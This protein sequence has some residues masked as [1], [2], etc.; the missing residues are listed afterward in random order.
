MRK[1]ATIG[2]R[3]FKMMM[4]EKSFIMVLI[5]EILLVSSS[6]FLSVGYGVITSPESSDLLKGARNVIYAGLVTNSRRELAVPL[7]QSGIAYF[8]YDSVTD[9]ENDLRNG[10]L[11]TVISGNLNL[12]VDPS[13][14]TVYLPTNTPKVGLTRLALKRFFLNVED[15]L[16]RVKMAIYSPGLK[17]LTYDDTTNDADPA[18]FEVFLIFTI[19]ILFFMPTIMAGSLVI[20]SLTEDMESGRILNLLAAPISY[21]S[22]LAGKLAASFLAT[23]PHCILWLIAL[24]FTQYPLENPIGI[25]LAFTVYTTFFIVAG[26]LISLHFRKN[27]PSQMAYTLISVASIILLSPTVNFSRELILFSPAHVYTNLALGASITGFLPQLA[28]VILLD[29][30]V[31]AVLVLHSRKLQIY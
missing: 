22:L 1:W 8:N 14:I 19:P 2:L 21:T 20:D 15:R 17:L 25:L 6:A 11:D 23:I 28:A 9:A 18:N 5:F 12:R 4:K 16:R 30:L 24:S 27:R 3:E 13:V 26:A 29:G 10:I 31:V 7:Q